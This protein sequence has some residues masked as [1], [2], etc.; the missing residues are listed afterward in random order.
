MAWLFGTSRAQCSE[1]C[2]K[3]YSELEE[4]VRKLELRDMEA[5]MK[6][7]DSAEK[8]SAKLKDRER[9][10]EQ[11]VVAERPLRPWER[12]SGIQPR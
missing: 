10:R 12:P 2:K 11:V 4:R 9:K 3:Q 5:Y 6:L 7:M 8:V 1:A